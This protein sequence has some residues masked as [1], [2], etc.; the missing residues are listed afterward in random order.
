[1][2]TLIYPGA[3]LVQALHTLMN[4]FL[5]IPLQLSQ[6]FMH[7][8]TH[9]WVSRWIYATGCTCS[10]PILRYPGEALLPAVCTHRNLILGILVQLCW[11]LYIQMYEHWSTSSWVRYPSEFCCHLHIHTWALLSGFPVKL[12]KLCS[13][14]FTP[15]LL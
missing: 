4:L 7:S 9:S 12:C 8:G 14:S 2:P 11:R 15:D 6:L 10:E 5:S 1:V 13:I 3:T